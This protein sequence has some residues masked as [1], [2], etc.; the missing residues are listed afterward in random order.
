M[1][2]AGN[3]GVEHPRGAGSKER[4]SARSASPSSS[5]AIALTR[6][7]AAAGFRTKYA[8]ARLCAGLWLPPQSD[9]L[10]CYFALKQAWEENQWELFEELVQLTAGDRYA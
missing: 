7:A 8:S 6:A 5:A 1:Y 10:K 9:F 4:P 2:F 3:H